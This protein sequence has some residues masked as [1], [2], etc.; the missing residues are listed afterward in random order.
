MHPQ[1]RRGIFMIGL[2][3]LA[4]LY[5]RYVIEQSAAIDT[6][7]ARERRRSLGLTAEQC[8]VEFPGLEREIERA[9][10]EGAF[11]LRKARDDVPGS[12]QGRI[13]DGKVCAF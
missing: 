2:F 3:L 11:V 6:G 5:R 13:K 4:A 8:A 12:V 9:V 7:D 1:L 10:K